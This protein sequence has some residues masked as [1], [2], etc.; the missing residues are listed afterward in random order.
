[1]VSY[2]HETH[3]NKIIINTIYYQSYYSQNISSKQVIYIFKL[4]LI[5]IIINI[6]NYIHGINYDEVIINT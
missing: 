5:E 4:V 1:M 6:I 2:I 3:Y